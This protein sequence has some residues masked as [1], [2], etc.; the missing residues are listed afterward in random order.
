[1]KELTIE[2]NRQQVASTDIMEIT[3]KNISD[4]NI[5]LTKLQNFDL[6]LEKFVS[7][8]IIQN[9]AGSTVKEYDDETLAKAE[10]DAKKLNGSTVLIEYKIRITNLGEVDGYVRKVADYMPSDLKFSSEL[11]KD[12]YQTSEGLY[13]ASIANDK[14]LAG[15]SKELTLTLTKTMTENNVGRINNTAEIAEAYN[16]LGLTDSNSTP[17]NKVQGE[18]DYGSADVILSI[19]TGG[20]LYIGIGITAV[21]IL[22]IVAVVI[23]KLRKNKEEKI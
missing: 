1:M 12:W 5:G 11:N 17:G 22:A 6:K 3:D 13:N 21:A 9:S 15:Q 8:I 4:I 10:L 2:G 19:K 14:I 23:I 20:A 7:K 18:N 16:D